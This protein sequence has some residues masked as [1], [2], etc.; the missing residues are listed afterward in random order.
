MK[1]LLLA[2]CFCSVAHARATQ[3]AHRSTGLATGDDDELDVSTALSDSDLA[4]LAG[5][6]PQATGPKDDFDQVPEMPRLQAPKVT[7]DAKDEQIQNLERSVLNL[8]NQGASPGMVAFVEELRQLVD[9]KMKKELRNQQNTTQSTLNAHFGAIAH[10]AQQDWREVLDVALGQDV[11]A[12]ASSVESFG[13]QPLAQKHRLCRWGEWQRWEE[14]T[15]TQAAMEKSK[16]TKDYLCGLYAG[17]ESHRAAPVGDSGNCVMGSKYPASSQTRHI[18]FLRD[19]LAWWEDQLQQIQTSRVQCTA[20]SEA[21]DSALAMFQ[22]ASTAHADVQKTCNATQVQLDE[23]SCRYKAYSQKKC[24]LIAHCADTAWQT[25]HDTWNEAL[26]EAQFL[27][28]Q[29]RALLRIECY[30]GAFQLSNMTDGILQCKRKDFHNHTHV[31]SLAFQ[32]QAQPAAHSCLVDKENVAGFCV[33]EGK[34]YANTSNLSQPCA[35]S[36]CHKTCVL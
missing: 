32:P 1:T 17:N 18:D 13:L 20:A 22:Q 5:A 2:W 12:N 16:E 34:Y 10:C 33:Y 36:C 6:A 28:A 15:S 31:T 29:M 25:Y 4:D 26:T 30:L 24:E 8:V 19:Q 7:S 21:Y 27:Q 35:A 3:S 14:K 11:K 9:G 23:A